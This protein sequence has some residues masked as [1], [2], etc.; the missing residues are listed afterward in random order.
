MPHH[1]VDKVADAL[2]SHAKAVRGSAV[3]VLGISYKR[4]IDDLR[5]SPALD[6]LASLHG[7]GARVSYHDPYLPTLPAREW[8]GGFDLRS[9]PLNPETLSAADCTVIVTDHRVM[10]YDAIVHHARLVLDTRNA[11][12][13]PHPHVFKLGAP[14]VKK[15]P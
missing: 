8:P 14:V 13:T 7:K 5:E 4:D 9:T 12:K 15:K 2:N 1:V 10:D 6:V 11:I 3:F